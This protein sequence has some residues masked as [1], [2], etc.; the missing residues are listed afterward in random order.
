MAKILTADIGGTNSRFA[1]FN[2]ANGTLEME[3][4]IWLKT[5]KASSFSMLLE[6][7]WDSRFAAVPGVADSVV[8]AV[9]GAVLGGVECRKLP[10]APWSIDIRSIN[11]GTKK[12]CLINDFAAQAY[13]CR[14]QAVDNAMVIQEGIAHARGALAVVG[15]GTGLGYSALVP[16]EKGWTAIPSEG[17]H[18][19]FPFVG[20]EEAEYAEFNRNESGRN[21]AE[22]DSVVT[23]LGLTLV[24][25]FLTGEEL[26]PSEISAKISS[27]SE[28]AKWYARFYGRACRNWA[29]ALM[30]Y[31]GLFI[32]GGIAA[33][34]QTFVI[35]PE[36]IE[37]FHNSHIYSDFLHSV[38]IKL[39]TNEESGLYGAAF[40][41]VQL[42]DE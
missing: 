32:A 12:A 8:L 2:T 24:H 18:M 35:V 39:N 9:A 14:T 1:L 27:D 38:P 19:A 3:D 11:F 37:E 40:Y 34:N 31:G 33:K 15:A 23:G 36:F 41:G 29:F 10:N 5:H 42:L 30:A 22:G 16:T 4:S 28:T 26:T 6:Q 20:K 13:A 7:L 17:G 21:W 25:K